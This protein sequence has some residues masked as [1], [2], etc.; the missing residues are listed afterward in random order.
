[1][2]NRLYLLA[3]GAFRPLARGSTLIGGDGVVIASYVEEDEAIGDF[4]K[5]HADED[6]MV[7]TWFFMFAELFLCLDIFGFHGS[8][9]C[10]LL[11]L[12]D[13]FSCP[14]S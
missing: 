6:I 7:K 4:K 12:S 9:F 8:F 3:F 13:C 14:K 1:M 5:R 2:N 11:V 10:V